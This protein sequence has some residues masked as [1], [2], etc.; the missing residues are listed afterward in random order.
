YQYA[1]FDGK[2]NVDLGP[3]RDVLFGGRVQ[4]HISLNKPTFYNTVFPRTESMAAYQTSV[5][6][7]VLW[8]GLGAGGA[9]RSIVGL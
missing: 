9:L 5:L 1:K 4:Q 2:W 8:R 7:P 6:D 3:V